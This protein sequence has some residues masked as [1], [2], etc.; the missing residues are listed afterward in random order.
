MSQVVAMMLITVWVFSGVEGAA[1]FSERAR[2]RSDVGKA[3]VI[4]FL[5]VLAL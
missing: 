4:G 5:F 1:V 2:R 3:T